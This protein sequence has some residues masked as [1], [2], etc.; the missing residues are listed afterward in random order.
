MLAIMYGF[1]EWAHYLKGNDQ[2]TEVL[3][4]H[5]NLTFFRKPQNL[6]RR[7]ARWILNL[8]E[9]NF[10]ITHRSGKSNAKADLLTRRADYP[11]GE[12]D[13]RDV[14]LLKEEIFRNIEI[15][16]DKTS[17]ELLEV[18]D[19][20]S[21]I[22]KRFYDKQVL[23][24]IKNKDPD[25]KWNKGIRMWTWKER[26]YIPI[27]AKLR[28]RIIM[29]DHLDPMA[30]HPGVA[31]TLELITRE[32]WWPRMKEDIEKYI[33]ACHECQINKPDRRAKAAPL[34][35]NEI[36]SEPWEIISIDLIGP[37]VPSKGKD[38]ILV[39]VNQFSKKAYFLPS[40]TTITSKGVANLY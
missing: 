16:L 34:Q 29:W 6:N 10:K 38:M 36:P 1:Y 4:D 37:M 27:D 33:K 5:Q 24:G 3:T 35:P 31:K 39:V 15:R 21:K 7:Q 23:E 40:N 14:I 9:Y 25:F 2:I 28:E 19:Q 22:H 17:Y 20:A 32:Y 12:N 26:K 11:K 8:Q 13:N 18:R 30:R